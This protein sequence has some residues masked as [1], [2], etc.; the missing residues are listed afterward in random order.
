MPAE[1]FVVEDLENRQHL[2]REGLVQLDDLDL[3]KLET[4]RIERTRHCQGRSQQH[5]PGLF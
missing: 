2:G 3:I 5:R 1:F 4:R